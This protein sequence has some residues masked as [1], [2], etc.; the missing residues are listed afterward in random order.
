MKWTV[1]VTVETQRKAET[2]KIEHIHTDRNTYWLAEAMA[3]ATVMEREKNG[4]KRYL[5]LIGTQIWRE[6]E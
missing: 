5:R 2:I 6:R 3:I 1:A 4:K